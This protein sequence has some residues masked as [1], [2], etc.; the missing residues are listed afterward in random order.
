MAFNHGDT[1]MAVRASSSIPGLVQPVAIGEQEF[2]D[3]G[4]VSQVPVNLA[5][6]MGADIV[7]AVDVTKNLLT[8]DHLHSTFAVMQQAIIIMSREISK[9]E[10]ETADVLIR[11]E[12]GEISINE[13][14]RRDQAIEAGRTAALAVISDIKKLLRKRHVLNSN[15]DGINPSYP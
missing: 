1:G 3:G 8:S 2:I 9:K 14:G 13:F 5:R 15:F 11:P 6:K 10:R 12:V 7:I 4:L